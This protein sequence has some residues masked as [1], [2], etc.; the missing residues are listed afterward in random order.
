MNTKNNGNDDNRN[1]DHNASPATMK[2]T[3]TTM[4]LYIDD[5]GYLK[6]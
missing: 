4:V 6:Y 3:M 1:G 5:D 2:K